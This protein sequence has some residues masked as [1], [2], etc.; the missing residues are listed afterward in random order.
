MPRI[1]RMCA[2]KCASENC[3]AHACNSRGRICA[4]TRSKRSQCIDKLRFIRLVEKDSAQ[5]IGRGNALQSAAAA[6]RHHRLAAGQ[7][8]HRRHPEIL[9]AGHDQ[10]ARAGQQI[11]QFAVRDTPAKLDAGVGHAFAA[12]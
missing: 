7:R 4:S 9:L 2:K 11:A 3:S 12:A 10:R 6:Q 1:A 5:R 8:L